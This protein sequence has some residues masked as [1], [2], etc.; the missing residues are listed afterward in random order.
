MSARNS[1]GRRRR[2]LAPGINLTP[3]LDA[4]LN[5]TFFFLVATTIRNQT[6][7]LEVNLP[8]SESAEASGENDN[9]SVS[10]D[11]EGK[12]HYGGRE[13]QEPE[14]EEAMRS[15]A[16]RGVKE[17][18]IRGDQ[19]VDFGRVVRLMDICKRAGLTAANWV[20]VKGE[21]EKSE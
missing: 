18:D 5:L 11:A 10:L 3:L 15:L 13:Y 16:N 1:A 7:A 4:I 6:G 20:A 12:I 14:F 19:S 9:R 17:V 21:S 2:I 8:S